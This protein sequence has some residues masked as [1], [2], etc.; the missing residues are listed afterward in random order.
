MI[1][2]KLM[3]TFVKW[4]IIV[5]LLLLASGCWGASDTKDVRTVTEGE[6]IPPTESRSNGKPTPTSG[7]ESN[8][9]GQPS[10]GSAVTVGGE[11]AAAD[12][13]HIEIP[14]TDGLR[15][16]GIDTVE[17]ESEL[18]EYP[19][20]GPFFFS[21]ART[22]LLFN[23][24]V[25]DKLLRENFRIDELYDG[26][27]AYAL[28]PDGAKQT[29][30]VQRNNND[31]G[32]VQQ[33]RLMFQ[34]APKQDILVQLTGNGDDKGL[35]TI[36][37]VLRYTE[38]FT[39]GIYFGGQN[40]S[41]PEVE[42]GIIDWRRHFVEAGTEATYRL[43]F[44]KAVDRNSVRRLLTERL[45][46]EQWKENWLDENS[47]DLTFMLDPERGNYSFHLFLDGIVDR[48]GY[49]LAGS[50]SL[51]IQPSPRKTFYAV[52]TVTG[53]KR[54]LFDTV[55][56]YLKMNFS[57]NSKWVIVQES[58]MTE[59]SPSV[60]S[61]R[62]AYG[63]HETVKRFDPNRAEHL[64]WLPGG[65]RFVYVDQQQ[66]LIVHDLTDGSEK[67]VWE[68]PVTKGEN[69]NQEGG[70]WLWIVPYVDADGRIDILAMRTGPNPGYSFEF[71]A[72]LYSLDGAEDRTPRRLSGFQHGICELM[73]C[74]LNYTVIDGNYSVYI[75][76]MKQTDN[77]AIPL[78]HLL[79][80]RTM[81]LSPL[82]GIQGRFIGAAPDGRL[83][84][85]EE[86]PSIGTAEFRYEYVLY[87]PYTSR[88]E[89][90]VETEKTWFGTTDYGASKN[91][92]ARGRNQIYLYDGGESW[93]LA[94]LNHKT[95]IDSDEFPVDQKGAV[96]YLYTINKSQR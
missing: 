12:A 52:N 59:E 19:M 74:S 84:F 82:S 50:R 4:L 46:Y 69:L 43:E 16:T 72:D 11:C 6:G 66:R 32:T 3:R 64:Q 24:S 96:L 63:R 17:R 83:L 53:E 92:Y 76:T 15:L 86:M 56:D 2:L 7:N 81:K 93:K 62:E 57:P 30:A 67:L 9:A 89:K 23:F 51:H 8:A 91:L 29:L 34:N 85:A 21:Q 36:E 14:A 90:F 27:E 73:R 38:P 87:D 41:A 60:F 70:G 75:Q 78:Y 13:D 33:I 1:H 58:R 42:D 22:D 49:V 44:S 80:R 54:Q 26:A 95:F 35:R 77:G 71:T 47:L 48:D 45:P 25:P 20:A 68:T 5:T 40:I 10:C 18:R 39:Y 65:D 55:N 94:H 88:S 61:I 31:A 28:L 37:L 79:D